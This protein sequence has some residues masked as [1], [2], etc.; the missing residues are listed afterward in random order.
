MG[1]VVTAVNRIG[2][3]TGTT[4]RDAHGIPV[5]PW[6][7]LTDPV[8]QPLLTDT[9]KWW[10]VIGVDEGANA[11]HSDGRLYFFFGDVATDQ[12]GRPPENA[13]LVAWTD[14]QAPLRH[15]G[16]LALGWNFQ[17]P[18]TSAGI[19]GQPDW[20]FCLKCSAL[21][22]NGDPHFKGRCSRGDTHN[23]FGVGLNFSLPHEPTGIDGQRQWRFCGKCG[24]LF[25]K[26]DPNTTGVC[27]AGGTHA[28]PAGSWQFVVPVTGGA[29]SGQQN[30]RFCGNCHGLFFD[31]YPTKGICAGSP[32]GGFHLNAITD[33]KTPVGRFDAFRGPEPIGYTGSFETPNGAFSYEGRMYV[34]AGF[35]DEKYSHRKRPG[36][37]QP[38]QYLFSKADPSQPGV[39]DF[40]YMLSPKLGWCAHDTSR[41]RFESH[42]PLG[43]HFVLSHDIAPTANR[44][45]GWRS[46]G[47]CEALF[48]D[49]TT[50]K[51]VCQRDNGPHR[52]DPS[53]PENFSLEIGTVEDSQH[54]S[55]WKQCRDCMAGFWSVPD[56]DAGLCPAGGQHRSTGELFRM[57]HSSFG[58][59]EVG[60]PDWR[61]CHKCCSLYFGG[62]SPGL[63]SRDGGPHEAAGYNFQV[64]FTPGPV[65]NPEQFWRF[66]IKCSCLFRQRDAGVC[67]RDHAA[68]ES[69]GWYFSPPH[70]ATERP[71]WQ[72]NWRE[73]RRCAALFFDGY[74]NKGHC[75]ATNGG[76]ES[77][78]G[79]LTYVL[80]H[81]PGA[82]AHSR[83]RF[84]FC[85]RCHG[86]VRADQPTWLPW[87]AATVVDNAR[88]PILRH[89]SGQGVVMINYDWSHFSLAWMPLFPGRRPR[90][91][92]IRYFHAGKQQWSDEIDRS[93]GYGLFRHPFPGQYTHVSAGWL[94]GP[95][96]WIVLYGSASDKVNQNKPIIARLSHDLVRWSAPVPLFDPTTQAA[97][98]RWMHD[99]AVDRIHPNVP[100]PQPPDQ[101]LPGW[102]YGAFLIDRFTTWDEPSRTLNV[103]YVMSPGSPYQVQL[104]E[105][106]LVLPNPVA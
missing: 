84:R 58:P 31:G 12:S 34:L 27:P 92:T 97:Y 62:E 50:F 20:Q 5:A 105:T 14:E 103:V 22:W 88:H 59:Y 3:I 4:T 9:G 1:I 54:Q 44:R 57:A 43:L 48:F 106:T 28:A 98:G 65:A 37:P 19:E 93:D 61:F 91:D 45:S 102:A 67:P 96:C 46:C 7:L 30:W 55:N 13:D 10:N 25:W 75:P 23:T 35:A 85:V 21:F 42:A 99:P 72:T 17:L 69:A 60:Q 95:G 71:E 24:S 41:Q 11:E 74:P 100:P 87:T 82:D 68:H 64:P 16:H 26:G 36:D 80:P 70:D 51:G 89:G 104:M 52:P 86:M 77:V 49:G 66:C 40:E 73:C 94:P 90:F 78:S 76:H 53:V 32:G 8:G 15:G 101:N 47:K 83:D 33:D 6:P 63:C 38:G 81:N 29:V 39:Y 79:G 56:A 2:Q 18:I